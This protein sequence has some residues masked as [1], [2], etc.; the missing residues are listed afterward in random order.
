MRYRAQDLIGKDTFKQFLALLERA[1]LVLSPDSGPAH[2][3][4]AMGTKVLGL[5]ACTDRERCGPYSDLRWSVNHY[6][7]AARRFLGKP[8]AAL[9]WGKRVEFPGTMDLV[10]VD[11]VIERF[12]AYVEDYNAGLA[13]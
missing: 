11:E 9:R 5:Y 4:N 1:S 13:R 2:M 8:G 10:T 3:A 6:D 12:D 7:E